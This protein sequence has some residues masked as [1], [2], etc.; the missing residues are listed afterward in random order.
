LRIRAPSDGE[1]QVSTS[2]PF[3]VTVTH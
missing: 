3:T 1:H 2:A